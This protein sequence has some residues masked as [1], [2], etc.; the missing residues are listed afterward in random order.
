MKRIYKIILDDEE[1]D[2]E[3]EPLDEG[4]RVSL[5]GVTHRF[6]ALRDKPPL[7]SFLIDDSQV[8]EADI[9]FNKDQCELNMRNLPYHLQVFDPRR[10]MVSQSEGGPAGG[11]IQAPMPGK[12]V[13]VKVA[14][15][16]A[17][18]KG[19]ALVVLEAM[20]MQ[21]ELYSPIDGVVQ[22]IHVKAGE[23]AEAGQKLLLVV[24][25]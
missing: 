14:S 24:K 7:Y 16:D 2:V 25:S 21:N 23:T 19:Q 9:L 5:Q 8:L 6:R 12:V 15:G 18:S 3:I 1:H 22:E 10:R 4:Y 17:V 11:L 20:K 13:E